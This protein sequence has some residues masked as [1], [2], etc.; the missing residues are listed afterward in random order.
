MVMAAMVHV[1]KMRG[2]PGV[3]AFAE[4]LCPRCPRWWVYERSTDG[5]EEGMGDSHALRRLGT[6]PLV[7]LPY[8]GPHTHDNT[9][10]GSCRSKVPKKELATERS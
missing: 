7:A 6:M 5:D 1:T 3:A 2:L 4:V 8:L 10:R 9:R